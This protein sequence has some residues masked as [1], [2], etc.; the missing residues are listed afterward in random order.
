MM[1]IEH[2]T[3]TKDI[4]DVL[5]SQIECLSNLSG[6]ALD[7]RIRG[8]VDDILSYRVSVTIEVSEPYKMTLP[9]CNGIEELA[10][11]NID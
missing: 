8:L 9:A 11:N 6:E 4:K 10:A 2:M 5:I 1:H 7:C 3:A